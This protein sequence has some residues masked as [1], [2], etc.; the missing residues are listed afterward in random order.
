[1]L[2]IAEIIDT[3]KGIMETKVEMVKYE[4][5]EEFIGIIFRILLLT[6]MVSVGLLVLLF[7]SFSFA[8]FLSQYTK[9]PSMGFL[10]VGGI[11]LILLGVLYNS[12]YS[13]RMQRGVEMGLRRFIFNR[14]NRRKDNE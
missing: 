6:F 13:D 9:S 1:M 4:I 7:F 10:I 8:F 5:Q 3:V 2:K 11:Y 14:R 12:R